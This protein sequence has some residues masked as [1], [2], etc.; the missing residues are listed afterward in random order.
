MRKIT[1]M[2][3]MLFS[4]AS[5]AQTNPF[6]FEEIDT[7]K[8]NINNPSTNI[9]RGVPGMPMIDDFAQPEE[10]AKQFFGL[11]MEFKLIATINNTKIYHNPETDAYVHINDKELQK[12]VVEYKNEQ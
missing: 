12:K 6:E 4:V 1:I 10:R 3:C 9:N 11:T 7:N 5:I 2:C 8:N